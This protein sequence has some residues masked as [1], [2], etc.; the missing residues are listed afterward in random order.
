MELRH[1][2]AASSAFVSHLDWSA[3]SRLLRTNDGAY[4]LLYYDAQAGRQDT[5][6]NTKFRDV[7]WA[8][9]TCPISWAT[10]GLWSHGMDGS[11]VNHCD[12]SD[13]RHPDG[14]QLLASGD[15][16][17]KVKIFRYPSM[18]L[19]S[20]GLVCRGHSSHVTKVRF[21]GGGYLISTGGNDTAV[22]QWKIEM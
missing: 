12:R 6:G 8:T 7:T 1:T 16:F 20:Q 4:E 5:S 17:G 10:Q 14:Y 21:T 9:A 19:A 11:D 22:I 13:E 15:D 18:N 2:L 3:D